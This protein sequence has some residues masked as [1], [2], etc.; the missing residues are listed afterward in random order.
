MTALLGGLEVRRL[1]A[2]RV[3]DDVER[4]LLAFG[5]AAH[6][7]GFHRSGVHEHILAAAFRSDKGEALGG[8]ENFL[9]S[10]RNTGTSC[11]DFRTGGMP[12]R[13]EALS[14]AGKE[15]GCLVQARTE[16][17]EDFFYSALRL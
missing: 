12:V 13:A 15:V 14:V 8:I 3:G 16:G 1:R 2:A 11:I 5:Q 7:G 4:H 6:A 10:D 9:V 17:G